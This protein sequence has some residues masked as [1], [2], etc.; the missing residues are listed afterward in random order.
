[1][2]ANLPQFSLIEYRAVL[3]AALGRQRFLSLLRPWTVL[4]E[5]IAR[6]EAC[7]ISKALGV[8]LA[9][10]DDN[11]EDRENSTNWLCAA[12]CE[13]IAKEGGK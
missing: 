7:S 6:K 1:M 12:A 13:L 10:M 2:S 5:S 3:E 11:E 4:L 9:Q 8:A